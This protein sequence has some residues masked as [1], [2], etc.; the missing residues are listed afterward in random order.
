MIE[1]APSV[2]F[3]IGGWMFCFNYNQRPDQCKLES[4]NFQKKSILF[5]N[6][7]H[8]ILICLSV[9]KMKEIVTKYVVCYSDN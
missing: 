8:F 1:A 9:P 4:Y 3:N 6:K 7:F 5:F 2:N